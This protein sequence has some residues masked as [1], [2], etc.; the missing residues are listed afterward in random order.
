LKY[1]QR[2]STS[3]KPKGKTRG[4]GGENLKNFPNG[5]GRKKRKNVRG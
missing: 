3:P 2:G 1:C 4:G 5:R